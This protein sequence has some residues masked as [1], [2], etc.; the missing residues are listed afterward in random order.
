ME[1]DGGYACH[2]FNGYEL[3]GDGVTCEGMYLL[4]IASIVFT[5]ID[6]NECA[7]GSS[8]CS[9]GCRNTDGSFICTC[10][11]GYQTHHDDPTSCFGMIIIVM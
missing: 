3:G 1:L 6:I 4:Y 10:N 11:E 2:C 8:N 9:Q 5:L 7:Q